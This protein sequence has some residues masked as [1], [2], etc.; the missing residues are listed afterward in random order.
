VPGYYQDT[1]KAELRAE[2][3]KVGFAF[4]DVNTDAS[5]KIVLHFLL[6]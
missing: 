6:T 5:Y 1:L 3:R 4:L 2:N